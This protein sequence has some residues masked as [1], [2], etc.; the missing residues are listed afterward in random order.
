MTRADAYAWL[1]EALGIPRHECHIGLMKLEDC[2]RIGQ[3]VWDRFGAL[4]S[5]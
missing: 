1:S 3:V 5:R 2:V 4:S